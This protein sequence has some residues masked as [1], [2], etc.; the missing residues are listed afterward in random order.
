MNGW[1]VAI[2]AFSLLTAGVVELVS[3]RDARVM[4]MLASRLAY[5]LW[6]GDLARLN[7]WGMGPIMMIATSRIIYCTQLMR[8]RL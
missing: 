6:V 5:L 7:I 3:L 8:G 1:V 2:V 4:F